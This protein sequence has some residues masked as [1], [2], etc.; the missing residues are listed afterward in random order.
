MNLRP[1]TNQDFD[2]ILKIIEAAYS[3]FGDPVFLDGYDSD[4]TNI[5]ANYAGI[6]G[7]FVVLEDQGEII[8]THATKPI[9]S[10]AGL[11]GFRR[12]YL[13]PEY[14]GTEARPDAFSVGHRLGQRAHI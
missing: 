3:K 2:A 14:H 9:D 12:L 6:G 1:A 13:K 10:N 8:G 7:A 11:L 5:E 4:L